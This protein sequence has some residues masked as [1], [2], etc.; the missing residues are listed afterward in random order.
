MGYA[1]RCTQLSVIDEL[2]Q[3]PHLFSYEQCVSILERAYNT[4]INI[5][6]YYSALITTNS[7]HSFF[8][9]AYDVNQVT[10][11]DNKAEIYAERMSFTSFHGPLPNVY[12]ERIGV[13]EWFKNHA[14]SDFMNIFINR[15]S[16]ISYRISVRRFPSLQK[17]ETM[18]TNIGRCLNALAGSKYK[19]QL[20]QYAQMMWNNTHSAIG[21]RL[22]IAQYF[23]VDV[24]VLQFDGS[25]S[26]FENET[27]L[28]VQSSVLGQNAALG[29]RYF[30]YGNA[31]RILIGPLNNEEMR[32]FEVKGCWYKELIDLID[33]YLDNNIDYIIEFIP[34]AIIPPTLGACSLSENTWLAGR[35]YRNRL[36]I[37]NAVG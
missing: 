27:S 14:L 8:L 34:Q 29:Y 17:V 18:D 13:S 37:R 10:L 24:Q 25:F 12:S 1:D 6:S 33:G 21:L 26:R 15:L 19:Q 28:G 32:N 30:D 11:D 3:A 2:K 36:C 20:I 23:D 7:R 35:R 31:I 4:N 22:M 5:G 16:T 9:Y